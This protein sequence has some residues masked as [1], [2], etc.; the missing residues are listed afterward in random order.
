MFYKEKYESWKDT[1]EKIKTQMNVKGNK[2]EE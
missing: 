2:F 1:M